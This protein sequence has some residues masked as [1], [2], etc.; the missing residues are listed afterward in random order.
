M[1]L[2][3]F[4]M[5]DKKLIGDN[6]RFHGP[7]NVTTA[8]RRLHRL[9]HHAVPVLTLAGALDRVASLFPLE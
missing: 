4:D 6:Q 9:P 3:F 1:Q 5:K 2:L 7:T 8:A